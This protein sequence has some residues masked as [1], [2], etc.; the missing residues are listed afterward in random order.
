MRIRKFLAGLLVPPALL[1]MTPLGCGGAQDE[2]TVISPSYGLSSAPAAKEWVV[3]EANVETLRGCVKKHAGDIKGYRHEAHIKLNLEED[4]TVHDVEMQRSTLHLDKLE[5]CL[6]EALAGLSIPSSALLLR[7]S[8]PFSGGEL[9]GKDRAFQGVVQAAAPV[10]AIAPVIVIAAGVTLGLYILAVAAEETIE[11]VKRTQKLEKMCAA[12]RN[13][14][15]GSK[16]LPPGSD[17]GAE[18]DCG[19]CFRLC[20]ARG[21]WP[22]DK[23]PRPN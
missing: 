8:E 23:C 9:Q 16:P 1:A 2:Y 3:P 4:G 12:L 10:I 5:S 17:F 6:Q 14:C 22:E 11:A 13:E 15:L 21:Y 18:K 19:A 20:T 7:S